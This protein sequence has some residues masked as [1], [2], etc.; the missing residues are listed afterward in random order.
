MNAEPVAASVQPDPRTSGGRR[1]AT[2]AGLPAAP[3]GGIGRG[4]R[5]GDDGADR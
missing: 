2:R 1:R 5:G 3:P 4:R